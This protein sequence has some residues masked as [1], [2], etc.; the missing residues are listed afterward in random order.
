MLY[1]M[2]RTCSRR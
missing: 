2:E 1:K